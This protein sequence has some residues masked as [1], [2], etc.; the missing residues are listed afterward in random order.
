MLC[1]RRL[2]SAAQP[3]APGGDAPKVRLCPV[4]G[5]IIQA[6]KISGK[7]SGAIGTKEREMR[8]I[9]EVFGK[10]TCAYGRKMI[11]F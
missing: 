4:T 1:M 10:K 5:S 11:F 9:P 3:V 7:P 2:F 8:Q 6:F